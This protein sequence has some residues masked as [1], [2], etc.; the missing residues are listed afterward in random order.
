MRPLPS[1]PRACAQVLVPPPKFKGYTVSPAVYM[2]GVDI[3]P[4]NKPKMLGGKVVKFSGILPAGL[5]LNEK[6]GEISGVALQDTPKAKFTITATNFHGEDTFDLSITVLDVPPVFQGYQ[7]NPVKYM[8]Q[9]RIERNTPVVT[10]G[11]P[12]EFKTRGLPD[13]LTLNTKTGV[14]TGKPVKVQAEKNYEISCV[15]SGGSS[16]TKVSITIM[17]V[18][19]EFH[20]TG[21]YNNP[22]EYIKSEQIIANRPRLRASGKMKYA[23]KPTLPE[24]LYFD[25]DSG[26]ISGTP[27]GVAPRQTFIVTATNTGGTDTVELKITVHENA[28]TAMLAIAEN[29]QASGAGRAADAEKAKSQA[30]E[31]RPTSR[32]KPR[33]KTAKK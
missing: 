11:E 28:L 6:T 32:E 15:N 13:G 26:N 17:D 21:Y 8:L 1:L 33:R 7:H 12:K 4:V 9:T 23:I 30:A 31:K 20:G 29:E 10:G 25:T 5:I 27:L 16:S 3:E 19:P 18:P 2:R 22:A 24:G 14:I